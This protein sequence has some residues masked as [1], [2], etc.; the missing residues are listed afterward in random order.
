MKKEAKVTNFAIERLFEFIDKRGGIKAFSE[1]INR[2]ASTIYSYKR[3]VL[4]SLDVLQDIVNS[5]EDFDIK[6]I[7]CG[8][9]SEPVELSELNYLRRENQLL[10]MALE[11]KGVV[12]GKFE[13]ATIEPVLADVE[14]ASEMLLDSMVSSLLGSQVG[15]HPAQNRA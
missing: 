10:Q 1:K 13:G 7:V 14:G 11:S 12:L 15:S 5:Y 4:P 6:W 8:I 9:P 2:P 3:G